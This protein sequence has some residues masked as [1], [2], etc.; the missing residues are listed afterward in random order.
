MTCGLNS[1]ISLTSG[2]A[3]SFGLL[4]AEAALRQR[5]QRVALGQAGVDEAQPGLLDAEDLAG[6]V[7]LGAADVGDVGEHLG[8]VH[9]RVQHA[10]ALAARTRR[11]QHLDALGDVPRHGGRALARLVVG[12]RVHRH[13]TQLLS[14]QMLP[15]PGRTVIRQTATD[16]RGHG[17]KNR[18]C[19]SGRPHRQEPHERP[20]GERDARHNS[21]LPAGPLRAAARRPAP[22]GAAD[23]S[24][25]CSCSRS[26]SCSASGST[27][28]T[29]TPTTTRRSSAGPT[30]PTTEHDDRV[31]GTG[32]GRRLR[33]VR[34]AG[35]LVR[36]RRGRPAHG[37]GRRARRGDAPPRAASR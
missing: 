13:Q 19:H 25:A 18:H 34:A 24:S 11:D 21:G 35:P 9:L 16:Q 31:H 28:A 32:A 7:H 17:W 23:R 33:R 26:R 22:A 15:R 36:R 6:P 5:R 20:P 27:T 37:H 14:H 3:A 8:T 10:A 12:V 2:S 4:Q 29:A 30:S 1:R